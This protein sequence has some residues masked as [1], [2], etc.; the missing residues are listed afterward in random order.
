M[1]EIT[2]GST[3]CLSIGSTSK[4]LNSTPSTIRGR[5]HADHQRPAERQAAE[6]HRRQ[7]EKRR[8]H[9]EFALGAKLI[10]CEVCHSSMK[11]TRHQRVNRAG[12]K[13]GDE[14]L[15][16][17]HQAALSRF[18]ARFSVDSVIKRAGRFRQP[19]GP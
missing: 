13:T 1:V 14:D 7:H 17:G 9:D 2:S 3:P 12:G 10:V 16:Q 18:S 5:Q 19:A 6:F 8:Q 11:P 15:Q 4:Y